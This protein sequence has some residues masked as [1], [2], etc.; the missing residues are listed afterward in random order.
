MLDQPEKQNV[1][2]GGAHHAHRQQRQPGRH[3]GHA[4]G[5]Q[6]QRGQGQAERGADLAAGR[7]DQWRQARQVALGVAGRNAVADTGEQAGQQRPARRH[8]R[9][10]RL[11]AGLVPGQQGHAG[12]PDD[13]PGHAPAG[14]LVLQP[15]PGDQRAE[16]RHG[17]IQDRCQPGA[18]GQQRKGK[19]G[20]RNA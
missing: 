9:C 12:K 10:G 7:R 19:A 17:G 6:P 2:N 16:H 4:R 14:Q 13:Q 5:P 18:D 20:K 8:A 11:E 1:G 3:A 15:G